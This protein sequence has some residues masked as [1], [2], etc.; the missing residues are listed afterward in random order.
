[1]AFLPVPC[2]G[3][4]HGALFSTNPRGWQVVPRRV[5][6]LSS[7]TRQ[8]NP[9]GPYLVG[10]T[11]NLQL[12][13]GEEEDGEVLAANCPDWETLSFPVDYK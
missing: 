2:A 3:I 1:M 4:P 8:G 7:T 10:P 12:P 5:H 13:S 11:F 6:L 9:I